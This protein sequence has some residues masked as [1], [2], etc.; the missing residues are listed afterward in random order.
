MEAVELTQEG[1][2]GCLTLNRPTKRN[3]L[4][5]EVMDALQSKLEQ[6]AADKTLTVVIIKANGPVF[7]AGHD[8]NEMAGQKEIH[9]LRNVFAKCSTIMQTV[10]KLPQ[11]V[12]AQVQGVATAAGCQLVAACDLAI[13]E[14]GARFATP[15][16]KIGLFCSTPMIPLVRLIGRRRALEMLLTGRFVSARE[17]ERFGLVNRV[18]P[19]GDLD[20]AARKWAEEIAAFSSFTLGFGKQTF[21]RQIDLAEDEAYA[22][23]QEA[24]VINCQAEDAQEGMQ[25]FLEKRA[26]VWRNK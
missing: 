20:Q 21:Y 13:A 1:A 2:I 12:I 5:L 19:A 24:M 25:A 7:C 9:Y 3:A 22:F 17:A 18:V 10:H 15:G 11:P 23:C 6:I 8:I 16:V 4:S 14:E 26:P